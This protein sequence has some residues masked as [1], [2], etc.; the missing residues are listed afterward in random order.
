MRVLGRVV[1][2]SAGVAR[3]ER[4]Y[5]HAERTQFQGHRTDEGKFERLGRAVGGAAR[6]DEHP[7]DGGDD[8][9]G[10]RPFRPHFR[11]CSGTERDGRSHVDV[12]HCLELGWIRIAH[13]PVDSESGVV[14]QHREPRFRSDLGGE[15]G[16]RFPIRQ[17]ADPDPRC[18]PE[19]GGKFLGQRLQACPVPGHQPE[20]VAFAGQ[21]LRIGLADPGGGSGH[22]SE[23]S[24]I[25]HAAVVFSPGSGP[26]DGGPGRS[27]PSS[28]RRRWTPG[29]RRGWRGS[30][31]SP[32]R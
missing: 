32:P 20:I 9:D 14:D 2:S 25:F 19:P 8:H 15:R 13:H 28:R 16:R 27:S 12:G 22:Q 26:D 7:G 10:S 3:A 21:K 23:R 5:A 4:L 24:K 1:E 29:P 17:V 30:R 18:R 11:S 31:P 6:A